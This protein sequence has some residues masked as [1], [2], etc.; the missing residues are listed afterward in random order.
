MNK[1]PTETDA[2]H[3]G[4]EASKRLLPP[5]TRVQ[6][7]ATDRVQRGVVLPYEPQYSWGTFPVLCGDGV[8]R[9]RSTDDCVVL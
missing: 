6:T 2:L 7:V 1:L 5:G 9:R 4:G 3:R 8:T